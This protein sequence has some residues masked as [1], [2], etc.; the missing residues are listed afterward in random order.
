M[1]VTIAAH[2]NSKKPRVEKDLF[3][4]LQVYV[5][6]PALSGRANKAITE[7]LA[8]HFNTPKSKVVLVKG[9]KSKIKIL[10]LKVFYCRLTI[11]FRIFLQ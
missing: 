1:K 9:Q 6:Q 10:A 3:G 4:S 2:V 11:K 5:N 7:A 8:E